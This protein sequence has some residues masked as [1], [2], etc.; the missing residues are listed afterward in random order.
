MTYHRT[1]LHGM[2]PDAYRAAY[3]VLRRPA[4]RLDA[5][6]CPR[7]PMPDEDAAPE[8]ETDGWLLSAI[9]SARDRAV[10][11]TDRM[12]RP[13][14]RIAWE[15]P[16]LSHATAK[17]IGLSRERMRQVQRQVLHEIVD[18]VD[19]GWTDADRKAL[20]TGPDRPWADMTALEW[21]A[22]CAWLDR[23]TEALWAWRSDTAGAP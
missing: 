17:G 18:A 8:V 10:A 7:G 14:A 21:D 9:V 20:G 3:R 16:R 6:D 12:G 19:R 2:D 5:L 23:L 15:L 11:R 13:L 1:G 4:R 22:R